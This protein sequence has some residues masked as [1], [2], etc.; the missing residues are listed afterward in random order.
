MAHRSKAEKTNA[1]ASEKSEASASI[2]QNEKQQVALSRNCLDQCSEH[3][4]S[5]QTLGYRSSSQFLRLSLPKLCMLLH[6]VSVI[7]DVIV[8]LLCCWRFAVAG[9]L[10][11]SNQ[12]RDI[13]D[14][15][16]ESNQAVDLLSC[17]WCCI[18][19]SLASFV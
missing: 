2:H 17:P 3:D 19:V 5:D 9:P 4:D 13:N 7:Q 15:V 8:V 18:S 6:P 16:R 12:T 14:L 1:Q 10:F 11:A